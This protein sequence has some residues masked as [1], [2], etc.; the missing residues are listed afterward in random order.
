LIKD[1]YKR[2]GRRESNKRKERKDFVAKE[3]R[4]NT[5]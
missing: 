2:A 3:M 5:K 1:E 4:G